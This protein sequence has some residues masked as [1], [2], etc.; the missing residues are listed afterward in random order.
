MSLFNHPSGRGRYLTATVALATSTLLLAACG[1]SDSGSGSGSG[2]SKSGSKNYAVTYM[3]KSLGNKYFEASDK[4][5]KTAVTAFG[6]KFKEAGA[7]EASA[8]VAVAVHP[9]GHPAGGR[10]DRAR[11]Q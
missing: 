7:T 3:P 10:R 2:G 1:S 4:G 6:G 11:C 5:G 9:D 8:D